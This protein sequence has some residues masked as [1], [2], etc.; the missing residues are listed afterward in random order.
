MAPASQCWSVTFIATTTDEPLHSDL[1]HA[2]LAQ[3]NDLSFPLHSVKSHW[4]DN[5]NACEDHVHWVG[6]LMQVLVTT[7]RRLKRVTVGDP[8]IGWK[9][10][11]MRDWVVRV[12]V[13]WMTTESPDV[14]MC[15]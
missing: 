15:G 13:A 6:T 1:P 2:C 4:L 8:E 7:T 12:I 14:Y 3:A 5:T 11:L 10:R 9:L